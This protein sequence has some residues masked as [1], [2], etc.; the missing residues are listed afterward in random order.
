MPEAVWMRFAQPDTLGYTAVVLGASQGKT[1]AGFAENADAHVRDTRPERL[2]FH[3]GASLSYK[4]LARGAR[5]PAGGN[6]VHPLEP[7]TIHI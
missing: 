2:T 4:V 6:S 7:P 3:P 5:A 1:E